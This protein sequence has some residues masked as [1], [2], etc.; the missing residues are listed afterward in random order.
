[1]MNMTRAAFKALDIPLLTS[2]KDA[3][4]TVTAVKPEDFD[5]E[6]FR[7]V[8]KQEFG[9]TSRRRPTAFKR[10]NIPNRPYGLLLPSRCS[11]ND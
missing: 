7:K 3:S 2:D 10:Q 4:P 9:L 5:A 8:I 6:A 1:M 11:S